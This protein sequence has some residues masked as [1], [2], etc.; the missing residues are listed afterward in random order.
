MFPEFHNHEQPI[1]LMQIANAVSSKSNSCDSQVANIELQ[2]SGKQS[3]STYEQCSLLL[4][5]QGELILKNLEDTIMSPG[6]ASINSFC[7]IL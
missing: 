5:K 7:F 3:I 6:P 4:A 1:D 2:C